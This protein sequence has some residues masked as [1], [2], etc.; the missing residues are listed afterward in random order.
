MALNLP[1]FGYI[2]FF[3]LQPIYLQIFC[4][5]ASG[6]S[7]EDIRNSPPA[8]GH[9]TVLGNDFPWLGESVHLVPYLYR[10][11]LARIRWTSKI[12]SVILDRPS[13][14]W[15]YIPAQR[16]KAPLFQIWVNLLNLWKS[17]RL[18]GFLRLE[19]KWRAMLILMVNLDSAG[20]FTYRH[21]VGC[22]IKSDFLLVHL[23]SF[24][25]VFTC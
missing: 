23:P 4:P 21:T 15:M 25:P 7:L 5:I 12:S 18:V 9:P 11:N 22:E 2:L 6:S 13:W 16:L 19:K 14:I 1:S 17:W 10:P 8:Y 3:F 24:L 20:T